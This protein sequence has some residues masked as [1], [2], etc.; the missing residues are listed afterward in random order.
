MIRGLTFATA[1]SAL[2][3]AYCSSTPSAAQ[4]PAA[5]MSD[6]AVEKLVDDIEDQQKRFA[7][8]L[9]SS[10]RKS[11]LRGPGGEIEVEGYL[12]DFNEDI[13]RFSDR[14]DSNYSA[15]AEVKDILVRADMMNAYIH[16][17]PSVKG[18]NEW[19]VLGSSLQQ[20]AAVYGSTFP[21]PDDAV[22]RRIGDGELEDA[23]RATSK[24][25]S[26]FRGTVRHETRRL[27]ELKDPAAKLEDEISSL[28]DIS[29]TLASRIRKDKPASA[30]ARQLLDTVDNIEALLATPGMPSTLKTSWAT[31]SKD[32]DKIAQAFRL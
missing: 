7:R 1:L 30:E 15:S 5:R 27:D 12:D 2:L 14:F 28:E 29:K 24:F 23:A 26:N 10:F 16:A 19:D 17:N 20:L 9:N 11:V 32:I 8:A 4:E 21:L 13:N 3:V 31:S 18:A 6:N 25:A 22:I